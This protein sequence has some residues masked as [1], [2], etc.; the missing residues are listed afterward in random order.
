[1]GST[2]I[3]PAPSRI[4]TCGAVATGRPIASTP[5]A[6]CSPIVRF[7]AVRGF[8]VNGLNSGNL[9]SVCNEGQ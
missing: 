9:R 1:M 4:S 5:V 7:A 6:S 2:A 3:G 8:A